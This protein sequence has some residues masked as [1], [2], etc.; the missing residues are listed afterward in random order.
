VI[1]ESPLAGLIP[2][3]RTL[4][5]GGVTALVTPALD[6]VGGLE[7]GTL[8][9]RF[10]GEDQ[11][12]GIGEALRSLVASLDDE[13]TLH[14]IHR[15]EEGAEEDVREYEGV[16]AA[17]AADAPALREYVA[18]RARWLRL[19][20]LRRAR[21]YLFFS[22]PGGLKQGIGRGL[23][24]GKL[25]F[26]KAAQLT[27]A[28]H[29][30]RLGRLAQLRDRVAARLSA[31]GIPSRELDLED[32]WRLHYE[33][34][35]PVRGGAGAVPP[36]VRLKDTLWSERAVKDGGVHLAEYTEAE[37]LAH[38]DLEDGRGHF[39]QGASWRRVATLKVLP[40]SGTDYFACEP[41][42]GLATARGPLPYTPRS[43]ST[44]ARRRRR[45]GSST[46]STRSWRAFAR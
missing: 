42:L 43:R 28:E 33:L 26:G 35:N 8:D 32:V 6:Y 39:R 44:C 37:Q 34:L 21:V 2:L 25:L 30:R 36:R 22:G 4:R 19:Q 27:E 41:L 10:A 20:R 16:A 3:W 18:A 12:A 45:G 38:E 13:T 7:L 24:G 5:E 9:V 29:A 23:L 14:F 40:E 46:T 31:A 15:I 17:A 1:R 11:I